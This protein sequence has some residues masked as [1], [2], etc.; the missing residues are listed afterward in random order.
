[1]AT[2]LGEGKLT[3]NQLFSAE[4][5]SLCP[6]LHVVEELVNRQTE[7]DGKTP[8]LESWKVWWTN[9]LS[10]LPGPLKSR[11]LVVVP[12]RVLSMDQLYLLTDI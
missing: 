5:L 9:S 11:V 10:L 4:K 7:S 2:T 8:V 3:S 6:I 1:M 12:I